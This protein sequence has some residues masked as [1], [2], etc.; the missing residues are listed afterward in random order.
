VVAY[1]FA[2]NHFPA[3]AKPLTDSA[4]TLN[5]IKIVQSKP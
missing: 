5:A 4:E 2:Q 3:G 1:I